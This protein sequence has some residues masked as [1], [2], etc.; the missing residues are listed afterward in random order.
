[1]AKTQG[2]FF[3][4]EFKEIANAELKNG[5]SFSFPVSELFSTAHKAQ[6]KVGGLTLKSLRAAAMGWVESAL[7]HVASINPESAIGDQDH[8]FKAAEGGIGKHD[9]DEDVVRQQTVAKLKLLFSRHA[10]LKHKGPPFEGTGF[11]KHVKQMQ[12]QM[13]GRKI[14][15]AV[16]GG[17]KGSE[18]EK[19][20]EAAT[21]RRGT[22]YICFAEL[23]PGHA[24]VSY[25][26]LT[27]PTILRV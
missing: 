2:G 21:A 11:S 20:V 23:F 25:T 14:V 26:H 6:E 24:S 3:D 4:E 19:P 17:A 22:L 7:S 8:A 16:G 13:K 12:G 10:T 15:P 18:K 1:M 5:S 27:L 9:Y